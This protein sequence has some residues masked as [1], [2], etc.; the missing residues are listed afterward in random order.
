MRIS[1]KKGV[2]ASKIKSKRKDRLS[3]GEVIVC[4]LEAIRQQSDTIEGLKLELAVLQA[5]VSLYYEIQ[6]STYEQV[7][8]LK[9]K[10]PADKRSWG[11]VK[12]K[13]KH[14]AKR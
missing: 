11:V 2:K 13:P 10:T 7:K 9:P 1:K 14:K 5:K 3:A 8:E 4:I 6:K 12:T